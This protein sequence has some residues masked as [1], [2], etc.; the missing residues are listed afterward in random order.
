[1][2]S[3]EN[4]HQPWSKIPE[5]FAGLIAKARESLEESERDRHKHLLFENS[6]PCFTYRAE[7]REVRK[8]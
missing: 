2:P 3:D 4:N 7:T 8:R 6:E 5:E 1:M